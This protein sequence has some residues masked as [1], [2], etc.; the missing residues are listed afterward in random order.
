[1][2]SFIAISTLLLAASSAIAAPTKRDTAADTK[3]R[4][5]LRDVGIK[6]EIDFLSVDG[7][8]NTYITGS[9]K[10]VEIDIGAD[11]DRALRC[12]VISHDGMKILGRRGE[13]LDD[14]FSDATKGE[15]KFDYATMVT[16]VQCDSGFKANNRN[17]PA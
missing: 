3:V 9:F 1:M 5:I 13:N 15:W 7:Y 16:A 8:A 14:T 12:A 11:V 2:H 10:T 6:Q 17:T 4:V